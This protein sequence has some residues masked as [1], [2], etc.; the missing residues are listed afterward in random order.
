MNWEIALAKSSK[1]PKLGENFWNFGIFFFH[2]L[3]NIPIPS[4]EM[5]C[6][7]WFVLLKLIIID[8][9]TKLHIFSNTYQKLNSS[10]FI[11]FL[12]NIGTIFSIALFAYTVQCRL[13]LMKPQMFLH[14]PLQQQEINVRSLLG[15]VSFCVNI[16]I[17]IH[18]FLPPRVI[19]RACWTIWYIHSKGM[20]S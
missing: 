18:S 8:F 2:E 14:S 17:K 11:C 20:F 16:S 13:Y 4:S 12:W 5:S 7:A 1:S 19:S 6:W 3:A 15:A 9:K 10:W